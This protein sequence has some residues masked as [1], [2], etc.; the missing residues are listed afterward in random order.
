[1]RLVACQRDQL[2]MPGTIVGRG[3]T[4]LRRLLDELG[5]GR[6]STEALQQVTALDE[7]AWMRQW[8]RWAQERLEESTT[9]EE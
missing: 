7:D 2:W 1:M 8:R 3:W 9:S 4:G 6:A 5:A